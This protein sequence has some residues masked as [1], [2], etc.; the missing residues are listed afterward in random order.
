MTPKCNALG[1]GRGLVSR[2]ALNSHLIPRA[3]CKAQVARPLFSNPA[4]NFSIVCASR[5]QHD[6]YQAR[7]DHHWRSRKRSH[8]LTITCVRAYHGNTTADNSN[9]IG[10]EPGGDLSFR[11]A[12]DRRTDAHNAEEVDIRVIDYSANDVQQQKITTSKALEEFLPTR[13]K[14]EWAACRWIY[15]NGINPEVLRCLGKVNRLHRLAMEDVLDTSTPTKVDWYDDHCF[16][17]MTLQKLVQLRDNHH[18]AAKENSGKQGSV[19]GNNSALMELIERRRNWRTL[20]HGE[21]GVSVEQV[22]AFLTSDNTVITIFERS[23]ED[24]LTPILKRLQSEQTILRSSNDPSMLIQAVIDAVVDLS[25]PIS[26]AVSAAFNR[27]EF[28]V[29]TN[30][31]IEQS[32]QLYLLR[33]GL[34]TLMD[35][36]NSLDGLVR[37]L[38]DHRAV[39]LPSTSSAASTTNNTATSATTAPHATSTGVTISPL[40]QVYLQDVHD[41]VRTLSA[42][43]HMS[44]RAAENL[45]AL[46]FN[47]IAATQNESVR[48]LT[49]VSCFFLPLTFLTGYFGM[50]FDP[51]PIVN[52]HSDMLFWAIATPVMTI[53]VILLIARARWWRSLMWTRRRRASERMKR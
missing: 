53:T 36:I 22:S 5:P 3:H 2:K 18:H 35:N 48:Q 23:G 40:A 6:Q 29:L 44:I 37:T 47:T 4:R 11:D 8:G 32:K 42:S 26:K 50:N 21:F 17:E 13:P 1:M 43:T 9:A 46:I 41:H 7:R 27:L 14:P 45:T 31:A 12:K 49:L 10:S 16:M 24:V 51:M 20:S 25:L 19:D 33:S 39:Q 28:S 34:T 38:I 30:P 52:E 15:V